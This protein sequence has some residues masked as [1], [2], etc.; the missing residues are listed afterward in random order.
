MAVAAPPGV[1]A[2]ATTVLGWL[3]WAGGL[4][5][6]AGLV[7]VGIRVSLGNSRGEGEQNMKGLGYVIIGGLIVSSASSI[8]RALV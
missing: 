2:K 8:A 6:V 4:A 5:V 3:Q 7:M 1:E